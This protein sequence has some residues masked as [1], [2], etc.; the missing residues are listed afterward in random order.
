MAERIDDPDPV[1]GPCNRQ[2]YV[3]VGAGHEAH[4]LLEREALDPPTEELRRA[5]LIDADVTGDD[6]LVIRPES[7]DEGPGELLLEDGDWVGGIAH[8]GNIVGGRIRGASIGARDEAY[9][10]ASTT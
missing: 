2:G 1:A 4:E 3:A 9:D 5:R 7:L 8:A 6:E 10:P